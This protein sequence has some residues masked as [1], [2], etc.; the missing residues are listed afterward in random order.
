MHFLALHLGATI[1]SALKLIKAEK[2]DLLVAKQI[3]ITNNILKYLTQEISQYE[4]AD[5]LVYAEGLIL[6]GVLDKL[7][8]KYADVSLHLR[9]I[10]PLTRLTQSEL[11]TGGNVGL[12][13]DAELKKGN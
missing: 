10:M 2:K 6:E 13:L 1:K 8:S 5:D 9:E 11:F 12:S 7:N 4:F 3:E